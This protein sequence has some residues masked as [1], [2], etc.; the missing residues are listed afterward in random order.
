MQCLRVHVSLHSHVPFWWKEGGTCVLTWHRGC[1]LQGL[2]RARGHSSS[3]AGRPSCWTR[4]CCEA[5]AFPGGQ[6]PIR[7][8]SCAGCLLRL[9][10][11]LQRWPS[12]SVSV[13]SFTEHVIS[14]S[15]WLPDGSDSTRP[16][17]AS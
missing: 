17:T 15:D 7:H 9:L 13:D 3:D 16:K 4:G 2:G 5:Q 14:S 10:F 1:D 6:A 12:S 8:V 11:A